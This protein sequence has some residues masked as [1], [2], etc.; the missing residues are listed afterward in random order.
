[1]EDL[2]I[3]IIW[4]LVLIA[5]L[6]F[7]EAAHG[8]AAVKLGDPTAYNQGMVSLDPLVHIKKQPIGTVVIPILTFV[9]AGWMVGWAGT[10]VDMY[11]SEQNRRKSALVSLAGP[12]TNLLLV[13]AAA[14]A[15]RI[16]MAVGVFEIP[17]SA[18]F[19]MI[20]AAAPGAANSIAVV[21]SV[22]FSLNLILFVFNMIPLPPFDGAGVLNFFLDYNT[23]RAYQQ[24]M[25]HPQFQLIG[26]I[27][28][29]YILSE[30]IFPVRGFALSLLYP[31]VAFG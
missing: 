31:G 2:S 6:T 12:V 23:A 27:V 29:W 9:L 4:Y 1:M 25:A 10:P 11:W 19:N 20:T 7:H 16:G 17:R 24:K 8:L 13:V 28:A 5:S 26:I 22:I 14:V 18:T 30:I 15:I 3:G 21:L